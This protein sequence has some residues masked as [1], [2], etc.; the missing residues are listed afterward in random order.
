[1][2]SRI[3][4]VHAVDLPALV[5]AVAHETPINV[6]ALMF[7]SERG[8]AGVYEVT[9]TKEWADIYG[10]YKAGCYG[11]YVAESF[12]QNL[13]GVPGKLFCQRY[14]SGS[15]VVAKAD[16]DNGDTSADVC[17]V[18]KA[19]YLS[20]E[21]VGA[22]GNRL[23]YTIAHS[24]RYESALAADVVVDATILPVVSAI[25]FE[26]G[27][28][29][30]LDDGTN[31][32]TKIILGKDEF[33]NTL[34]V[35][36]LEN[37]FDEGVLVKTL[38]FDIT[39][40]KKNNVGVVEKLETW[41]Y[42]SME[43]GV[44][45][46]VERVIN[47]QYKG[48][49]H[50]IAIDK[51]LVV[52]DLQAKLPAEVDIPVALTGGADGVAPTSA[53]WN[54]MLDAFDVYTTIRHMANAE[55]TAKVVNM[56]G[57]EKAKAVGRFIWYANITPDQTYDE[58]KVT[59]ADYVKSSDSYLMNNAQWLEVND[60]I[61][62]GIDPRIRIP[63]VGAIMG[64]AIFRLTKYGYQRVPAGTQE[65]LKGVLAVVGDQILDDQKRTVLA[66]LGMNVIQ[67][68]QGHGICLRNARMASSNIAYKWYN[69]IFMRIF[70]KQ[71]FKESFE[72]LE[73]VEGGEPLLSMIFNAIRSFMLSDFNGNSRTGRKPAFFI[74]QGS[75]FEDVVTIICD[76]SNNDIADVL[77]G[78]VNANIY[79]TPPPPAE[80]IEIGVGIS[81]QIM[82]KAV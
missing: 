40:Y 22:H 5:P 54:K 38:N 35:D 59:A 50:I 61:G 13:Q 62:I 29:I 81:L 36:K 82:A 49:K 14:I 23:M 73:N 43:S 51:A 41:K 20:K 3:L 32:E 21:D 31:V 33:E 53:D 27:D 45:T 44:S 25:G 2:S 1:M 4:G 11:K 74:T 78:E 56:A 19:G 48:S 58:L 26:I 57:E 52:D 37:D 8:P 42:L 55:A 15:A 39:I 16:I 6:A 65:S 76:A 17:L 64:H 63:N 69:Q 7:L 10:G 66:D 30:V 72:S 9:N 47:N 46:Y 60:P 34:T 70:Y 28:A 24:T 80:S 67:F 18:L 71:T 75:T 68:V 79:F 77:N 12:F